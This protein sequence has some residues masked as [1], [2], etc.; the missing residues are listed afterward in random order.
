MRL[1]VAVYLFLAIAAALAT[2][3]A[4][5]QRVN[6]T[7]QI[8][9]YNASA[10]T[11][12]V[13]SGTPDPETAGF[14]GQDCTR[15]AAAADAVGVLYKV[16]GI[17]TTTGIGIGGAAGSQ[18]RINGT[19]WTSAPG[20]VTSG[21][22]VE[23]RH[24]SAAALSAATTTTLGIGGVSANFVSTTL[25][26]GCPATVVTNGSDSGSGSLRDIIASACP[27]SIVTFQA[28]VSSVTLTT[29]ELLTNKNLSID[30]GAGGVTVTR[31]AAGGT[32]QFRIFHV[33]SGS[34]VNMSGLTVSN[35]NHPGQAGGIQNSGNLTLN[36]MQSTRPSNPI[37]PLPCALHSNSVQHGSHSVQHGW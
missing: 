29:A 26:G 21:D 32:P 19:T 23:A 3:P 25:S 9:C 5:A 16:S 31:S 30:G 35:G 27:A 13:S 17:T 15:G 7:G 4:V 10:S 20:E 36:N 33:T 24:T 34:I 6:D 14:K 11:G 22:S 8:A 2:L 37:L 18:Y 1:S 12:T 28:G